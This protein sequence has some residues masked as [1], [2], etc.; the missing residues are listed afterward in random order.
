MPRFSN[1]KDFF[2]QKK[3]KPVAPEPETIDLRLSQAM[4]SA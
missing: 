2:G 3:E 1:P 4:P